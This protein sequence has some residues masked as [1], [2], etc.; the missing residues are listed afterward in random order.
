MI[1]TTYFS[2]LLR[3]WQDEDL[4]NQGWLASLEDP[5]TQRTLYFKSIE[6]LF[7]FL[8]EKSFL[9]EHKTLHQ[10]KE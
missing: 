2:Y 7:K 4:P 8:N 1:T 5:S 3:L 9:K 10:E 6:D